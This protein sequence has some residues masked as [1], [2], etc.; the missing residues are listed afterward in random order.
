MS[1]DALAIAKDMI[2]AH[3]PKAAAVAEDRAVAHLRCGEPE[4]AALWMQVTR[5]IRAVV[6]DMAASAAPRGTSA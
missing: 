3:G 4:G 5:A 6:E 1:R 2:R